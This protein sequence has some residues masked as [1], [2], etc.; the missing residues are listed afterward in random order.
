MPINYDFPFYLVLLVIGTG[1]LTFLDKFFFEK[2]RELAG[3]KQP[4]YFDYARSFFPALFIVLIIRSFIIQP[5]RVPTGSLEPTVMPG[6]F[7][8]VKQYSYG[9]RLPVLQKKIYE[10]GEP[11][12]GDIALF[13][14][15]EDTAVRFIKRVIGLPGD[16]IV[17][18]NKTLTINGKEMKQEVL[19]PAMNE[20]PGELP[21]PV[22]RKR[23]NLDG[24]QHDIFISQDRG[25]FQ[26]FDVT[27]PP[28]HYFMMGD[29]RDYSADSRYWGTVPEEYL[30]GRAFA[31]WLSWD[32][33]KTNVRWN[34]LFT[35]IH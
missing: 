13:Y 14:Y 5:Y 24:V 33:N 7:I 25:W 20:D 26:E 28:R 17:Y 35:E 12:R 19:G 22:I 30:I 9:L 4:W 31:I 10:V 3:K 11:K 27:V 32:S 8:V 6:D 23:E 15:P 34:R 21:K 1:I 18:K 16:H 2:K 29:N